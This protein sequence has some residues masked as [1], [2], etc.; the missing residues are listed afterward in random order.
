MR[1]GR[2]LKFLLK[3]A[4]VG[5]ALLFFYVIYLDTVVTKRF[6]DARYEAPALLYSRALEL[7]PNYGIGREEV[8]RELRALDY[9]ET[10][11][12]RNPGEFQQQGTQLLLFRRAFDFPD[13]YEHGQRVRLTFDQQG[14]LTALVAWPGQQPIESIRLEPQ[15]IGRFASDNN[16]DRL[17]VGLE[18]VPVLM[19]QTLLLV[20]DREFYHH[21]G[22]RP[23]SILRA[24]VANVRAGRTVQGGSTITQQL[25]KNMFL[26]MDQNLVRKINEAIMALSLDYRFSKDEILEAY[27]NEVFF[28]QDRGHAIHGVGLGSQ[29]YFGKA[30]EDL[31]PAE[32]AQLV[33]MIRGPSL[34]NPHRNPERAQDRRDFVLRLMYSHDLISQTQFLAALEAP[35]VT[36]QN[37]RLVAHSRPDY[38]DLVQ[39]ELRRLIPGRAWQETGLRVFTYFDPYL[40]AQA[41]HGMT[42]RM[43]EFPDQQIQTA[44]VISDYRDGT[45]RALIG[46]RTPVNAGFNRAFQARR[47]IGSLLKPFVYAVA[48]ED[49]DQYSLASILFDEPLSMRNERG[50]AWEPKNFDDEFLGPVSL[51]SSWAE[52]R[53]IPAIQVGMAIEPTRL[54]D[55]LYSLGMT[56]SIHAYPSLALGTIE[57]SPLQVTH[58]YS[59]IANRG[60]AYAPTTIAGITTHRGDQLY[61]RNTPAVS[62]FSEEVAYLARYASHRVVQDGT[63]RGMQRVLGA[64]ASGIGGKTGSTNDLRDSWFV[65]F[66]ERYVMTTWMGRDD[67]QPIGLTGSRGAMLTAAHIWQEAGIVPLDLSMPEGVDMGHWNRFSGALVAPNCDDTIRLPGIRVSQQQPASCAETTLDKDSDQ[68]EDKRRPWWRRVFGSS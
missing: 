46:G 41:E 61:V 23:S 66:D 12:A 25:V 29:F 30:P 26:T 43:Q 2:Y 42:M 15:L 44:V 11:Y 22:V 9:R 6:T 64:S 51:L 53:N 27:F 45:I 39:Q 5:A 35:V 68:E 10:R 58:L 38:V 14:M 65:S 20:E 13:R 48:L 33:G 19:Q 52:S 36:R 4:L 18:Q 54:R 16:E 56:G 59:Y 67:N 8:V 7:R 31:N 24:A 21:Y 17:L 60:E 62:G 63:G 1:L 37:Y 49:S 50:Q 28:G 3:L 40:Q 47:Q 34:Y 32:I 57:L 55:H